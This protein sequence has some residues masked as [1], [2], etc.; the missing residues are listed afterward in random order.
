MHNHP[1]RLS[2]LNRHHQPAGG[3]AREDRR[4]EAGC[5]SRQSCQQADA[6]HV[7]M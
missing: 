1:E 6:A 5:R 4:F 7:R 2:A 3:T